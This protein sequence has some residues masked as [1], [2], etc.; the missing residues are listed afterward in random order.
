[1]ML[2]GSID[3]Y[4]NFEDTVAAFPSTALE[5]RI[6]GIDMLYSSGT[7]GKPK[8]IKLE[9]P[10]NPIGSPNGV[11]LF[12]Q[13]LFGMNENT[14]YLSPAPLYHAAPLRFNM[15]IHRLGAT[16]VI[17]DHFDPE[18]FLRLTEKYKVTHSQTVPTMFV[19][20]LKLD[21]HIRTKYDVSSL[22]NAFHAAAP[23]PVEVKRARKVTAS[24]TAIPSSGSPIRAPW[25]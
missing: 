7:T 10:S 12:G 6:D 16:T 13:M 22:V 14:V 20:M 17:M 8:G 1:L 5:N 19:R 11:A 9:L 4:E 25:V 2:D 3:G 21:E 15:A 24:S 23:C 18:E